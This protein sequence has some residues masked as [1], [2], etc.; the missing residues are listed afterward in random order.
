[1]DKYD[2]LKNRIGIQIN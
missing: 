1:V 2:N